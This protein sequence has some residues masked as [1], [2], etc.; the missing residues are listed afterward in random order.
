MATIY[1]TQVSK[2][3]WRLENKRGDV[4]RDNILVQNEE[5]AAE[6]CKAYISSFDNWDFVLKPLKKDLQDDKP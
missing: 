3:K 1:L 4:I 5:K 6:F 2:F